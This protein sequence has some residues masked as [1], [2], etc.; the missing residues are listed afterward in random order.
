MVHTVQTEFSAS[1]QGSSIK[2]FAMRA[3]VFEARE[4]EYT[5]TV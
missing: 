4:S 3:Q 5:Y 1:T 2:R